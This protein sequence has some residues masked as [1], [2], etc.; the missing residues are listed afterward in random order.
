MT[1]DDVEPTYAVGRGKPPAHTRFRPGQSGNPKG[2]PR[3]AADLRQILAAVANERVT[4]TENGRKVRL[5]KLEV[6]ARQLVN[7]AASGDHRAIELLNKHLGDPVAAEP[8]SA[9]PADKADLSFGSEDDKQVLE[10]F[11][12]RLKKE[13]SS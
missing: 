1:P 13:G 10:I 11:M 3:G 7:K 6:A 12:Q 8:V 4:I 9:P 2:R 5:T